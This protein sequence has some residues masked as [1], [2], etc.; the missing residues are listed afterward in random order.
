[1]SF[2]VPSNSKLFYDTMILSF[3]AVENGYLQARCVGNST[4]RLFLKSTSV[5]FCACKTSRFLGMHEKEENVSRLTGRFLV[6]KEADL[7][8]TSYRKTPI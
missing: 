1:M 8:I 2:K 6:K 3:P 5:G 7:V 4:T